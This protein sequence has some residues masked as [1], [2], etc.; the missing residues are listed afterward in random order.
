MSTLTLISSLGTPDGHHLP[1]AIPGGGL[2]GL[3]PWPKADDAADRRARGSVSLCSHHRSDDVDGDFR[4][5]TS[6]R[7]RGQSRAPKNSA[8][9]LPMG[10]DGLEPSTRCLKDPAEAHHDTLSDCF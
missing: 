5:A 4:T 10:R 7:R 2:Y 3:S 8:R 9:L 6:K 1:G